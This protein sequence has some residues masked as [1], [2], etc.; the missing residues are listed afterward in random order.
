MLWNLDLIHLKKSQV[1]FLIFCLFCLKLICLPVNAKNKNQRILITEEQNFI[2]IPVH[3]FI[4]CT[5][6]TR[7]DVMSPKV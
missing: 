2:P 1:S 5:L 3:G 4:S 6:L 7:A